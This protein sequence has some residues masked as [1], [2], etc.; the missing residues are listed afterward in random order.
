MSGSRVMHASVQLG[1]KVGGPHNP[2]FSISVICLNY[3]KNS[4]KHFTYRCWFV[5]KNT[6][7]E[8]PDGVDAEGRGGGN[9]ASPS[10]PGAPPSPHWKLPRR[11]LQGCFR[12]FC[13]VRHSW[14]SH[15]L[16]VRVRS[17]SASPVVTR[18]VPV[19]AG[20]ILKPSQPPRACWT[21]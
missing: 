4:R 10:S 6:A 12:S 19:A 17:E 20:S 8:Q 18:L 15:W 16:E 13:Y 21:T 1:Y 5:L 14:L 2:P 7:P 11:V 9:G 3:S